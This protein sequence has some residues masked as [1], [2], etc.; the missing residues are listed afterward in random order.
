MPSGLPSSRYKHCV[1]VAVMIAEASD[2]ATVAMR[3]TMLAAFHA[4]HSP[5]LPPPAMLNGS[6]GLRTGSRSGQQQWK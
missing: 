6:D 1:E 4:L 3:N 5:E 2:R